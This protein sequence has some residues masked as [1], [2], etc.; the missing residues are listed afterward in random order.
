MFSSSIRMA[1][2]P[3]RGCSWLGKF[4]GA[5]AEQLRSRGSAVGLRDNRRLPN[6]RLKLAARV[7]LWNESFFSAPQLKRGPLGGTQ[8]SE[9]VTMTTNVEKLIEATRTWAY[10]PWNMLR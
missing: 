2:L 10:M 7:G 1:G 8:P 3:G 5:Q 6:K 9:Q 4:V